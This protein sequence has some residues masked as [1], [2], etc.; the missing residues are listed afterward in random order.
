MRKWG[1][2]FLIFLNLLL[3]IGVGMIYSG[4]SP[5]TNTTTPPSLFWPP[6]WPPPSPPPFFPPPGC[7][8][9]ETPHS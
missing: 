7:R 4:K 8:N 5:H 2:P 9:T 3:A 1:W 6:P